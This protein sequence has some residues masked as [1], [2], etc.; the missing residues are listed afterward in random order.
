[1]PRRNTGQKTVSEVGI[2]YRFVGESAFDRPD[3]RLNAARKGGGEIYVKLSV[4][5]W[6]A[7]LRFWVAIRVKSIDFWSTIKV[8][9]ARA[10]MDQVE[11]GLKPVY[12]IQKSTLEKKGGYTN[13]KKERRKNCEKELEKGCAIKIWNRFLSRF[14]L[15]RRQ[16]CIQISK[17]SV[18]HHHVTSVTWWW[19]L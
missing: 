17:T 18:P 9:L 13:Q 6:L 8:F 15:V 11:Y 14:H 1:M 7:F 3:L 5:M 4:L 19:A 2:R 16:F 10:F 12:W